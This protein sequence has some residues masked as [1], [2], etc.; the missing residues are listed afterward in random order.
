MLA[1]VGEEKI[2][3]L[4]LTIINKYGIIHASDS[5]LTSENTPA[6]ENQKT[7]EINYLN[8]GLTVAGAYS[9]GGVRM[10]QWMN[11]FIQRQAV[12]RVSPLSKFANNLKVEL[13]AH[14]LPEE[15]Q[16]GSMVHIAGYIEENGL[17]HPEFW[18]V[19]NVTGIDPNTGEY[20]GTS[21]QFQ[22]SEDFWSRDC[23]RYKMIEAF[24][25]GNYFIYINGF[26]SGRIGFNLLQSELNPFFQKIW[27]NPNWKF[28]PPQ[29]IEESRM[30]IE[31]YIQTI[32]TLFRVSDYPAP[33]I[34][35]GIQT[36]V[37]S[38]PP[39]MVIESPPS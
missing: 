7:F 29:S 15:K 34:G 2:M 19:R 22:V 5:A 33:Y 17:S 39:N 25:K 1:V 9:V 13:E 27:S 23:P 32:I 31:L 20:T 14:M 37:I 8:A 30:F 18:F 35:G 11:D 12:L 38:R 10:D 3:T 6:G 21:P 16:N 36:L 4:I 24:Q 28:R 26:A